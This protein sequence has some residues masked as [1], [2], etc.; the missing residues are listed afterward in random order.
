MPYPI[1]PA[2][3]NAYVVNVCPLKPQAQCIRQMRIPPL[4]K[5]LEIVD[6]V[7]NTPKI[8]NVRG[9]VMETMCRGED[10]AWIMEHLPEFSVFQKMF[11]DI[12]TD[13]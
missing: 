2:F 9:L 4:L 13:E 11:D 5:Q 12:L 8:G 7:E 6:V 3:F 1:V 10:P